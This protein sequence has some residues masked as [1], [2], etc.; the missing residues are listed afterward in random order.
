[1]ANRWK[2]P[3]LQAHALL[4]SSHLHWKQGD[5]VEAHRL[6]CAALDAYRRLGSREVEEA[7]EQVRRIQEALSQEP[8]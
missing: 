1:M 5:V 3:L 6:A 8:G 7:T 4:G 2:E